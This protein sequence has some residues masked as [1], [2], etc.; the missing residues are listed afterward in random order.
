MHHRKPQQAAAHP[1]SSQAPAPCATPETQICNRW[2]TPQLSSPCCYRRVSSFAL[3]QLHV[4]SATFPL[5]CTVSFPSTPPINQVLTSQRRADQHMGLEHHMQSST[6][7][8]SQGVWE[9]GQLEELGHLDQ[10]I[11]QHRSHIPLLQVSVAKPVRLPAAG[12]SQQ[13]RSVYKRKRCPKLFGLGP[14][15]LHGRHQEG[16]LL[17]FS[18]DLWGPARHPAWQKPCPQPHT[19]SL[20][21][22]IPRHPTPHF[23]LCHVLLPMGKRR[24]ARLP[25]SKSSLLH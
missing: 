21:P 11:Q 14:A 19:P 12:S 9:R 15:L 3:Q 23:S 5:S 6:W 16:T 10:E 20:M 1:C 22:S 7:G 25:F 18:V 2:E 8:C 13:P 4:C 24:K 17:H